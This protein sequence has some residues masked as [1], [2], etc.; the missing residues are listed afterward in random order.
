MTKEELLKGLTAEQIAKVRDCKSEEELLELAHQEGVKLTDE[1]LASVSGG[2][3]VDLEKVE[4]PV[5][6]AKNFRTEDGPSDIG[7]NFICLECGHSW[8][9]H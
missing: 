6:H 8:Y 7:Y 1:Q 5:C 2:C 3:G 9:L 4:C